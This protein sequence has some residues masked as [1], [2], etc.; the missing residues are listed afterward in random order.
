MT[1]TRPTPQALKA[2]VQHTLA[3]VAPALRTDVPLVVG[4]SGGADSL[5]LAWVLDQLGYSLIIAHLD[6]GLRPESADQAR[7]VA[8]WARAQGWPVVVQRVDVAAQR[9]GGQ[10]LEDAARQARYTFLFHVA[11]AHQAQAVAV[12]HTQDDQ[13]ETVLLNLLRGAGL[14]GLRGMA[15]VQ[16]P[17]RWHSHLPL[18]RPLLDVPRGWTRAVADALGLPVQEDP[19]NRD[20]RYRRNWIRH[21]V[22]PLLAEANPNIRE[23]LAR[24][25]RALAADA[26]LLDEAVAARWAETVRLAR[27]N[28]VRFDPDAW[29]ALSPPWQA[30]LLR[31]AWQHLL[32]SA[33][34]PPSW[35]Q[36]QRARLALN[37]PTVRP[38]PWAR[39]LYLLRRE[40]G[41]FVLRGREVPVT[42]QWPA[43]EP[44]PKTLTPPARVALPGGWTLV[45]GS[46]VPAARARQALAH[47]LGP[48]EA[49]LDLDASPRPWT[50]R[51]AQPGDRFWPVDAA[52]PRLVADILAAAR[53]HATAR[54]LWPVLEDATGTLIWLPGRGAAHPQRVRDASRWA[55]LLRLHPPQLETTRS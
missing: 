16:V 39:G 30:R 49:W 14:E 34:L 20:L 52:G 46:P 28:W 35:D 23:T 8:E 10:S 17:T 41:V 29:D 7:A 13:A 5:V 12:A 1:T 33:V 18:V 31:R 55:V 2:R 21:R 54:R 47:G 45:I 19:S 37:Q 50:L 6:H 27:P 3:D 42:E 44:V 9:R 26:A 38:R 40:D 48:W 53:V 4:V 24:T 25:A 22:L 43:A 36:V 11:E 15:V 51:R 32:G